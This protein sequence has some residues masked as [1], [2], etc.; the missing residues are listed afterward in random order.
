MERAPVAPMLRRDGL[1]RRGH[2]ADAVVDGVQ[3]FAPLIRA[4]L[5]RRGHVVEQ[6]N[7]QDDLI[8]AGKELALVSVAFD[9]LVGLHTHAQP[10]EFIAQPQVGLE[11]K[12]R[13]VF[14]QRARVDH[15]G[16]RD[17]AGFVVR[18]VVIQPGEFLFHGNI[19]I[20]PVKPRNLLLIRR[21]RPEGN[22]RK[23]D[24]DKAVEIAGNPAVDHRVVHARGELKHAPLVAVFQRIIACV[25]Q[26]AL[27][28]ARVAA[29][30]FNGTAEQ[31]L[32][33]RGYRGG[34]QAFVKLI[35]AV[36]DV[37]LHVFR[38]DNALQG[39]PG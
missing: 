28:R 37:N 23:A 26:R 21:E 18:P 27:R 5:P 8:L 25:A 32:P 16:S 35:A 6:M 14:G 3:C 7:A 31:R 13:A 19:D 1:D 2:Q 10:A 9:E 39:L 22:H 20:Q 11:G 34:K 24:V 33:R 30:Q 4:S 29:D 17:N 12:R 15:V 38:R 36:P